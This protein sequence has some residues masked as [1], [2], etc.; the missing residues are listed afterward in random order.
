[1]CTIATIIVILH[2]FKSSDGGK[3]CRESWRNGID[4]SDRGASNDVSHIPRQTFWASGN[5]M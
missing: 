3:V 2:F 5:P 4:S 1:M